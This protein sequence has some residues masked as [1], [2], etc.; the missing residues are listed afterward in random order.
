[1]MLREHLLFICT[2]CCAEYV[3]DEKLENNHEPLVFEIP[4]M[5]MNH[6]DAKTPL[7]RPDT[8]VYLNIQGMLSK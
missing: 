4:V 5:Q 2:I 1:M 8:K 6:V 7:F 3:F